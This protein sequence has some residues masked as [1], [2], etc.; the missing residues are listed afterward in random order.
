MKKNL[1]KA[2]NSLLVCFALMFVEVSMQRIC[3][4]IY[5]QPKM[6]PELWK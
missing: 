4:A 2:V 3:F 5:H 1:C 6:P